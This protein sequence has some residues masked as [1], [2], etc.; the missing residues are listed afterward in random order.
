[1]DSC[2]CNLQVKTDDYKWLFL[3]KTVPLKI[4]GPCKWLPEIMAVPLKCMT[5]CALLKLKCAL[6][7]NIYQNIVYT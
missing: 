6:N 7:R 1:M 4:L 3:K 5:A 2:N